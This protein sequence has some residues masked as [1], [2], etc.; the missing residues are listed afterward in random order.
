LRAQPDAA[1]GFTVH[2]RL[3]LESDAS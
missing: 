2:A 3:P 1:G